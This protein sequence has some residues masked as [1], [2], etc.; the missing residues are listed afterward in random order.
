VYNELLRHIPSESQILFAPGYNVDDDHTA[1][2]DEEMVRDAVRAAQAADA[3]ILCV[4][5]PEIME[6]EGFDRAHLGMPAQHV[7]LVE[8]ICSVNDNVVV[9]LSNGGGIETPWHSMPKA[10]LEGYLLGEAGGAAV[11]DLIFGMQSP[12]GKLSETFAEQ[13][14]D[15]LADKYFPGSRDRVEY[16]EGL[17]VGYRYFDTANKIV[18]FPFGHGLSYTTFAYSDLSISVLDDQ[19]ETK[20]VE[21]TLNVRNSGSMA[22][23]EVVQ[24][25]IHDINPS[26]FRPEQELKDFQKI[27]LREGES[28]TVKFTLS[29]H[30][31]AFYDI[32]VKH[33]IVVRGDF[34]IR[35]GSSSRDIRLKGIVTFANGKETASEAA[36]S[37]YPPNSQPNDDDVVDDETFATRFG[38]NKNN[39]LDNMLQAREAETDRFN[40]NSLLKDIAKSRLVGK[41]LLNFVSKEASREIKQGPSRKREMKMVRKTVKNLPLRTLVL[42]SRG[43]FSFDTLDALIDLL[44][45]RVFAA[46]RG[47]AKSF[48]HFVRPKR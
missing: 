16:R 10:I 45:L 14:Q 4:G 23:K 6:S 32:G 2:V 47:F 21:V 30:A 31:F 42:F 1:D 18:R 8:A 37:S 11:V 29:E 19:D 43:H 28:K 5:L 26:V 44:N 46:L 33:W 24:V 9:A 38:E 39:V 3:V 7:A 15:I 12:C 25:F 13:R 20:K 36:R 17:L 35:L 34:E 27:F 22:G 41:I 40:R 48:Y